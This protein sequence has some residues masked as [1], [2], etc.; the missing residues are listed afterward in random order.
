MDP[1]FPD[2]F[3]N[4]NALWAG[5]ILEELRRHGVEDICISP[6]SRS[7][8]LVLA[9]A[10]REAFRIHVHF[11]ERALAFMA[12]GMARCGR[13]P[14]AVITTSGTA[15]GN[16]L[17]AVME[18]SQ[19]DAPLI[20]LT[21][22][23][24][25][26]LRDCGANQA[27][28]QPGVFGSHAAFAVD[29]PCPSRD[30]P[31]EWLLATIDQAL[32][33]AGG[34]PAAPVHI[35]C[36]FREPLYPGG[37]MQ[38]FRDYLA[39]LRGWRQGDLPHLLRPSAADGHVA[40]PAAIPSGSTA[41]LIVAGHLEPG[42]AAL[43]GQLAAHWRW[44]LVAD[45]G[46][47]LGL[48]DHPCL[49]RGF[50]E[51][52]R[53]GEFPNVP[54]V[55]Q[56]G[57]RL[58]SAALLKWLG[59]RHDQSYVLVAPDSRRLDPS[60]RA[61]HQIQADIGLTCRQLLKTPAPDPARRLLES[62]Q[63][64]CREHARKRSGTVAAAAWPSELAVVRTL[65]RSLAEATTLFCGNSL[66]IRLLDSHSAAA[67]VPPRVLTNRGASGIDGLIATAAGVARRAAQPTVA[68]LGDLSCLHDLGSLALLAGSSEPLVLI[69]LNNDGGGI[70]DLL[71]IP[72][73]GDLRRRLF[74]TPHGFGF[75]DACAGFGLHY[76][77]PA[78]EGD[79]ADLLGAALSAAH[80]TVLEVPVPGGTRSTGLTPGGRE[81]DNSGTN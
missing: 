70:F 72:E 23:R 77:T 8:P 61:S 49:L 39:G 81:P 44:P 43:V 9:A 41:G 20:L 15:V 75:A 50:R 34:R 2:R 58:T 18:A 47:Q 28:S 33:V 36:P 26:E 1:G 80:P 21:A 52:L 32:A 4:I 3:S 57:A 6:G 11:D 59:G 22:D 12:L 76:A 35:N 79:F 38:N 51:S 78:S 31:P 68:L 65:V 74:R 16:L 40:N 73:S 37:R 56:F 60:H 53:T 66:A 7:A 10:A 17:P 54:T 27:V 5:L 71:P 24:P 69:I 46:S 29:L 63:S 48:T 14:V 67:P 25:P 45:I 30:V 55:L 62:L 64:A 42:D 13:R 19:S